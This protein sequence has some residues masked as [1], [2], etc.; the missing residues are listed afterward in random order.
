MEI[1]FSHNM[2]KKPAVMTGQ[3]SK[4]RVLSMT[5]PKMKNRTG[6]HKKPDRLRKPMTDYSSR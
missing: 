6:I 2:Q 1:Y 5:G 3:I 4:D